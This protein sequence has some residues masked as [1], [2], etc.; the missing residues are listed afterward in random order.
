MMKEKIK[1]ALLWIALIWIIWS[2]FMYFLLGFEIGF[3][4]V[5]KYVLF[6]A[7][8]IIFILYYPLINKFL[9]QTVFK[10]EKRTRKKLF[11]AYSFYK[12]EYPNASEKELLLCTMQAC[13]V[14]LEKKDYPNKPQKTKPKYILT[15]DDVDKIVEKSN[16]IEDLIRVVIEKGISPEF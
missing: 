10:S 16:N 2:I 4:V 11:K 5:L 13:F 15:E 9:I 14:I 7:A 12:K 8:I 1:K 3:S 6:I